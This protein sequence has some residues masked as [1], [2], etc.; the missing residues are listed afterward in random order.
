M[1]RPPKVC[2]AND[3]LVASMNHFG[4]CTPRIVQDHSITVVKSVNLKV[5]SLATALLTFVILEAIRVIRLNSIITEYC[6]FRR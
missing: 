1:H 5:Q 2:S 3:Q 6:P 4:Q